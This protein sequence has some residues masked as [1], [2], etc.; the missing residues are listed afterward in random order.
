MTA[1]PRGQGRQ[2]ARSRQPRRLW[3]QAHK[4]RAPPRPASL[5]LSRSLWHAGAA[6]AR[7]PRCWRT[8]GVQLMGWPAIVGCIR[9]KTRDRNGLNVAGLVS[10]VLTKEAMADKVTRI[11]G[12]WP[13]RLRSICCT[14]G[15]ATARVAGPGQFGEQGGPHTPPCALQRV[16]HKVST[17]CKPCAWRTFV[18]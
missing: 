1:S 2:A 17:A 12:P 10:R 14:R 15:R 8:Q 9:G 13:R 5:R 11:A 18:G 6:A 3:C 16:S 7:A 4:K